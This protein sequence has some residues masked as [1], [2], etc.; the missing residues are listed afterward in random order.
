MPK[1][2][3]SSAIKHRPP[4]IRRVSVS[5]WSRGPHCTYKT[6]RGILRPSPKSNIVWRF[7]SR[8]LVPLQA[9]VLRLRPRVPH[10]VPHL[11]P[12]V[13]FRSFFTLL[14]FWIY[15]VNGIFRYHRL[16]SFTFTF[17][18]FFPFIF[19]SW[20]IWGGL[21]DVMLVFFIFFRFFRML[22]VLCL[23]D[24]HSTKGGKRW[25]KIRAIR[26]RALNKEQNS[27]RL[28]NGH[29]LS[30]A[31]S[32]YKTRPDKDCLDNQ[33]SRY[34]NAIISGHACSLSLI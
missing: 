16:P 5:Y 24:L 27:R 17:S 13:F 28:F 22:R 4:G 2:N 10:P 30:A 6:Q 32:P 19:L 12:S 26:E 1:S 34:S 20:N 21:S 9:S 15:S 14:Y 18:R 29:V 11:A 33:S 25:E 31:W 7:Q 3:T 8:L 23:L